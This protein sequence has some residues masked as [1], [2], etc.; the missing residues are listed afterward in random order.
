[1]WCHPSNATTELHIYV[2]FAI[3]SYIGKPLSCVSVC[4]CILT[5]D[6]CVC[7]CRCNT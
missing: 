7:L 4:I 2:G 5:H 1:M 3:K 6:G